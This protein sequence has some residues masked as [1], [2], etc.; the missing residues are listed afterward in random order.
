MTLS[1]M[2]KVPFAL[3]LYADE[4]PNRRALLMRAMRSAALTIAI[5]CH[6]RD[7]AAELGAPIERCVVIP[8]GVDLSPRSRHR[9]EPGLIV[10]VARLTDRYKGHD[11]ILEAL[12]DIRRHV[13]FV[14]WV[15]VGDGPLRE[16]LEAKAASLGLLDG[17]VEFVGSIDDAARDDWLDRAAV[18]TMPSRLPP[19]GLGGEGFG[20]VFLEAGMRGLPVVAGHVG[21]A[22]DA[23][24]HETTG[25]LVDPTS[26]A[27]LAGA[28]VRVLKDP[29]LARR[30]GAAGRINAEAHAWPRIA[31][32][33]E[34]KLLAL[35]ARP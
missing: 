19:Q 13:P 33:V 27:A 8:P 6:A 16:G 1:A 30:M 2:R 14:R 15:V 3:Y 35:T 5:S 34:Q 4:L 28:L 12:P 24:E 21:G 20:I 32:R 22:L 18:F 10:T 31:Q 9:P 29:V 26:P 7:L 11:M 17:V 23:I 25:L